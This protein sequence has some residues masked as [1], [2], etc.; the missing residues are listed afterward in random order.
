[1]P[2]SLWVVVP[3]AVVLITW[4]ITNVRRVCWSCS[5]QTEGVRSPSDRCRGSM[6]LSWLSCWVGGWLWTRR[7]S[8]WTGDVF[9]GAGVVVV[10]EPGVDGSQREDDA[11][12]RLRR[13]ETVGVP[14]QAG[15]DVVS[16]TETDL[17]EY[18]ALRTR[19][20]PEPVAKTTWEAEATA[21]NRL[22]AWL[23]AEGYLLARPWRSDGGRD[24]LRN[25]VTRHLR[26][27]H[28]TV[29]QY[30][31]FHDVGLAGQLPNGTADRSF[32]GRFPHRSRAGVEPGCWRGCGWASGRRCCCQSWGWTLADRATGWTSS[33][34][35]A[36]SSVGRARS[37]RPDRRWS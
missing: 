25:G 11:Q 4:L 33:L 7:Q 35:R 19:E 1:M 9:G 22:Y 16:A 15:T 34:R 12:V 5:S 20:Q 3:S 14:G 18:R 21:I 31:Y 8:C 28:M 6:G 29:D 36:R 24:S 17:L 27:R 10:S 30:R 23:V 37:T 32:R 26:V 2:V 13:V